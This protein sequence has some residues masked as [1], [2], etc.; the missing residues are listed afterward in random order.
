MKRQ[1]QILNSEEGFTL[2][3]LIAVLI[4]LGILAAV[5]VP[6]YFDVSDE[7]RTRA[8][9]SAVSQAKSLCSLAYGKAALDKSGEPS[10]NDVMTAL[11]GPDGSPPPIEGDFNFTFNQVG[12]SSNGGEGNG[13]IEITVTGKADTPFDGHSLTET[14]YLP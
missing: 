11:T 2:I 14:W 6:R 4:I 9:E 3:E 5:A 12:S 7:A 13:G 1:K 8:F 10:A